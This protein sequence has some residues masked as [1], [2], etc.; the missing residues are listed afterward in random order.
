M[1]GPIS[2]HITHYAFTNKQDHLNKIVYVF[3]QKYTSYDSGKHE[4]TTRISTN[5]KTL[6]R[7][8]N[9]T[10]DLSI[11]SRTPNP[12]GH[13]NDDFKGELRYLNPAVLRSLP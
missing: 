10:S 13:R 9:R 8:G 2:L 7:P 6:L 11:T 4:R 12:F 5:A 1:F 3:S